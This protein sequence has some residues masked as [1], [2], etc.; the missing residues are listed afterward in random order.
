MYLSHLLKQFIMVSELIIANNKENEKISGLYRYNALTL[1]Y[2]SLG[3]V[4]EIPL[5]NNAEADHLIALTATHEDR[6]R[7]SFT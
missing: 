3:P 5:S 2:F 7:M 1:I 4:R 6:I